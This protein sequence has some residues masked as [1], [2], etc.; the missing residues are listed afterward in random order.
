ME[1]NIEKAIKLYS[2]DKPFQLYVPKS[3]ENI[4]KITSSKQE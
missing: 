3:D 4:S 2:G 1:K